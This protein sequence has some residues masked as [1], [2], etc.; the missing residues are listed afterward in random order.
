MTGF[1]PIFESRAT[2]ARV[3]KLIF[4]DLTGKGNKMETVEGQPR[5]TC[6]N[7]S[8][9]IREVEGKDPVQQV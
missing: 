2:I 9:D 7:S 5:L 3:S 1:L 4:K 6:D 8:G